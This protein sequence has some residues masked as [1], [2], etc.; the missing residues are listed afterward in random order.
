MEQLPETKQ[1]LL[2]KGALRQKDLTLMKLLLL[3]L[4]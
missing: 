4:G 1:D 2:L 3:L